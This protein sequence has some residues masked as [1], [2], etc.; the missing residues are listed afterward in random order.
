MEEKKIVKL[1]LQ[2]GFQLS[3][4]AL[5][6]IPPNPEEVIPELKKIKPRPFIVTD[7]HIKK[8]LKAKNFGSVE[9]KTIKKFTFKKTPLH[10][11]DCV[12]HLSSRYEK[13]KSIL[14]KRMAPKKLVS[15]NKITPRTTE[16][17]IIGLV[18]KRNGNSILVEDLTGVTS[19]YFDESMKKELDSIL[20]DDVVGIQ[21]KK[22]E[23]KYHVK[24]LI[25]PDVLSNRNVAKTKKEMLIAFLASTQNLT[26]AQTKKL[27]N[28]LL[29]IKNL[30]NIFV[31]GPPKPLYLTKT[32][33]LNFVQIPLDPIP[34]LFQLD[35]IKIL[36]IP[37]PFLNRFSKHSS[38]SD[39]LT[40][41]LKKRELIAGDS[42]IFN[43]YDDFILDEVP[44]IIASNFG[45]PTHI[46]Y[47]GTTIISNSNPK[48]VFI[49][50]LKTRDV[51]Q[52]SL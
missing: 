1:F 37:N 34:K 24:K 51:Q 32:P 11:N 39:V 4:S 33:E 5:T 46:N 50:N 47:K 15:I 36:I 21:C 44:D 45:R 10:V 30:S 29:G 2:N 52:I 35:V 20:L 8:I 17:S 25:Y 18:K 3:K 22:I 9:V 12:K 40:S 27:T 13:I 16:F 6:I 42:K 49:V 31:F 43:I 7:E 14:I 23:E 38:P 26:D 48:K 28:Y 41:I 19:L